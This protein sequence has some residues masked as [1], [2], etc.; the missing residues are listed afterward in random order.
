MPT[1]TQILFSH[2][3][4]GNPA[5]SRT[6]MDLEGFMLSEINQTEKET[7]LTYMWN[8]NKTEQNQA[9]AENRL[10]VARGR[11]RGVGEM[12]EAVKKYKFLVKK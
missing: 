3:K 9:H 11:E 6:W 4:G 7:P 10:V 8:Q 2:K 1:H 12:G 5:I